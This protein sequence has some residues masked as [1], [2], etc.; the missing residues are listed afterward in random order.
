[1]PRSISLQTFIWLNS[2]CHSTAQVSRVFK[3][4]YYYIILY[5]TLCYIL[6]GVNCFV[7][8]SNWK[9]R[10][11]QWFSHLKNVDSYPGDWYTTR[12]GLNLSGGEERLIFWPQLVN[13]MVKMRELLLHRSTDY[14]FRPQEL[15]KWQLF[16]KTSTVSHSSVSKDAR[17]CHNLLR[18][19]ARRGSDWIMCIGVWVPSPQSHTANVS[20]PIPS[21]CA[22]SL[23]WPV[24][25]LKVVVC[26]ARLSWFVLLCWADSLPCV[27]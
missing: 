19:G 23:K 4:L 9:R 17:L 13:K 22:L 1:M 18:W 21:R 7:Q 25:Y 12:P 3:S 20:M 10:S 26:S 15:V 2:N 27:L 14:I 24:L 8:R 6:S 16:F 11:M 5:I